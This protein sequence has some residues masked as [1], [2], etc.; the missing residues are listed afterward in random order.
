MKICRVKAELLREDG[1]TG[2]RTDTTKLT[3]NSRFS[4]FCVGAQQPRITSYNHR[5]HRI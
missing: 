3:T 2:K 1:W 5:P 4:Q